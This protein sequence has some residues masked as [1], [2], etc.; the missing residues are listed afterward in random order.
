MNC[1]EVAWIQPHYLTAAGPCSPVSGTTDLRAI[2][3]GFDPRSGHLLSFLLPLI[4]EG[5]LSVTAIIC[6]LS[7]GTPLRKSELAQE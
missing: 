2:C 6:S 7:T 3:L 1:N 5:Q 4:Q